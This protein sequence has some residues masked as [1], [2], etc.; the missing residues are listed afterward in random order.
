MLCSQNLCDYCGK[1]Y[2]R[3]TSYTRH[4][5][6]CEIIHKNKREKICE[7]EESTDIP[8]SRQL[9]NIVQELTLK[10]NRMEEKMGEMQ[11]WVE[12]K[13]KKLNVIEWLNANIKPVISIQKW[14]N[15]IQIK[16]EHIE[17]LMNDNITE[18]VSEILTSNCS[19]QSNEQYH[20]YPI[21]CFSQKSN[22][23]Y[24]YEESG[25][26]REN[27]ECIWKQMSQQEIS[28]ILNSI[29]R[30]MLISLSCWFQENENKINQSEKLQLQYSKTVSK[31]VSVNF[32]QESSQVLNKIKSNFY[33][34]LKSDLKNMIE[35]EFE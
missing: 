17:K 26:S 11:I 27:S 10:C 33:N 8:S 21:Y 34:Y 12:K 16:E 4:I 22:L 2:T 28:F 24:V 14:T 1:K 30:K 25:E 3:K 13:K 7:D 32:N 19:I 35:Y 23:F 29:I 9:Y 20:F 5:I 15:T 18:I 31:V 6:L